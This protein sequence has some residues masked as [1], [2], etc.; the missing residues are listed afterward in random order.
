LKVQILKTDVQGLRYPHA[1]RIQK[2]EEGLVP[3]AMDGCRIRLIQKCFCLNIGKHHRNT[4]PDPR[5]GH[6][7]AGIFFE[8]TPSGQEGIEMPDGGEVARPGAMR[9]ALFLEK[10]EVGENVLG[11]GFLDAGYPRLLQIVNVAP[12]VVRISGDA[13]F[14]KPLFGY[15]VGEKG[16]ENP[17]HIALPVRER[18]PRNRSMSSVAIEEVSKET[19]GFLLTEQG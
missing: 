12:Q 13:V 4:P 16:V 3:K 9:E 5:H 10:P 19:V 1:G 18:C 15:E 2:L 6:E 11:T 17:F 7:A 8:D 14:R